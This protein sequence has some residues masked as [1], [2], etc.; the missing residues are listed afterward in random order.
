MTKQHAENRTLLL[1]LQKDHLWDA[2]SSSVLHAMTRAG[3]IILNIMVPASAAGH[4]LRPK[5]MHQTLGDQGG[6]QVLPQGR[7]AGTY[8]PTA[9]IRLT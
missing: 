2:G 5:Y 9:D 4:G 3:L 1:L 8:M 7:Y 6:D